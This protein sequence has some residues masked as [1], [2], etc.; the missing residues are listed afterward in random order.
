MRGEREKETETEMRNECLCPV[1]HMCKNAHNRI[2]IHHSQEL[3]T[4]SAEEKWLDK[5]WHVNTI[6]YYTAMTKNKLLI[7]TT[8]C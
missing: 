1:R 6:E 2:F 5:C 7:G 8:G 4:P 3:E